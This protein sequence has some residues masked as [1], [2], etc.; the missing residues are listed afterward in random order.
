MVLLS[1]LKG[2]SAEGKQVSAI[3]ALATNSNEGLL[4]TGSRNG[5]VL[6]WDLASHPPTVKSRHQ[7][8]RIC[9]SGGYFRPEVHELYD[10]G[11]LKTGEILQV[12][13]EG[14][15]CEERS[16]EFERDIVA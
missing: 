8:H 5:E 16:D 11:D 1:E 14:G 12:R 15:G 2:R 9:R 7:G 6:I 10:E 4:A 3:R 13:S